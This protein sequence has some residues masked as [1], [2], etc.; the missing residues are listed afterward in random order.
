MKN[1]FILSFFLLAS[2]FGGAQQTN[3]LPTKANDDI[4]DVQDNVLIKTRDGASISAIVV[5]KKGNEQPLPA[6]LFYTTYS[7]GAGGSITGKKAVDKGYVGIVA[8]ARGIRTNLDDFMPYEHDGNDIY[9]VIDWISKQ[10]WCDGKVGMYGGSYTGFSQW[11]TVRTPHPALRTIVPQAAVMPGYNTPMVNNVCPSILCLA[12]PNSIL[13][14]KPLA[15]D[16]FNR[17]YQA[18]TSYRSLDSFAGQPNRI[19]QKWLQHPAYDDYWKSLVPSPKGYARLNF[20]ILTTTG[21]YDDAQIGAIKYLKLHYAYNENANHYLVIGPYNHFGA[22]RNAPAN[23]MGYQIDGVA[24]FNMEDVVFQ[25]FDYVLKHGSKPEILKNKINY[26]V[27]GANEWKHAS[28]LE[29]MNNGMLTLYLSDKST[30]ER[31]LLSPQKPQ[32][33][34]FLSQTV[35]FAD[36]NNQN[37]YYTPVII[38]DSLGASNGLT[39]MTEPFTETLS[40]N[41]SFLGRINASINKR[42]IDISIVLYELTPNGKYFY[43]TH[44]LGR[45]SY[46]KDKSTRQLLQP[47]KKE[48]IPFDDTRIVSKQI[49]QGSRLVI[50]LNVNKNAF[51]VINYG[52][53]KDVNDETINDA[54]EL[55]RIKWYN[56]SYI[57][58][59]IQN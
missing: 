16:L 10:S 19:F 49:E 35:D 2:P 43:L 31:H 34:N 27:M 9:D 39:F 11:S 20:P 55:L 51:E 54:K 46:A 53:G 58:V 45:A 17:W 13:N 59:P 52:T 40:I 33:I 26:E 32:K 56:D 30:G 7:Q 37:N 57:K 6:I 24:N 41:G 22:Q 8:Y 14:N 15:Q 18:G 50:V 36:R 47:G 29:A 48:T 21:Y 42:D 23:L 44:Y 25:W 38:N 1:L 5:R 3:N 4:Y 28:S 12:W